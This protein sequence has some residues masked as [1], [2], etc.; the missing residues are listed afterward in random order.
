MADLGNWNLCNSSDTLAVNAHQ[1]IDWLNERHPGHFSLTSEE[2]WGF[3]FKMGGMD[4]AVIRIQIGVICAYNID[5]KTF[6]TKEA[7]LSPK[8]QYAPSLRSLALLLHIEV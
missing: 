2:D 1:L 6:D 4:C 8:T 3:F 7:I 5:I